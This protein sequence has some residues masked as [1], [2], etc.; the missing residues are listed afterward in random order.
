M[1]K[2]YLFAGASSTIAT[3]TAKL[4]IEK[5]NRVVG[6]SSRNSRSDRWSSIFPGNN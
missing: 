4:L 2:N 3:E 6:I 1:C 5:G